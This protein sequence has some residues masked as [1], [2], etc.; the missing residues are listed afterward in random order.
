MRS[1]VSMLGCY[2]TDRHD[3]DMG[4]DLA[5]AI[6]LVSQIGVIAAYFHRARKG[7]DLPPVRKDLSEAKDFDRRWYIDRGA[8]PAWPATDD[9]GKSGSSR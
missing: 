7:L 8:P 9:V 1:A 3:L 6:K 4:K 5:N 2:D